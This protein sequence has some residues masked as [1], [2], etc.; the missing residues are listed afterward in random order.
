MVALENAA[1]V[2]YEVSTKERRQKIIS[3]D[4]T[5]DL[6]DAVEIFDLIRYVLSSF[7]ADYFFL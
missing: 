1:P 2:V 6:I 3:D 5:E 7:F 4:D